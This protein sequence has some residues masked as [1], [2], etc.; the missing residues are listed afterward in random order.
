MKEKPIYIY[1]HAALINNWADVLYTQL[2]KVKKSGLYDACEAIFIGMVGNHDVIN[3]DHN[4]V[5]IVKEY[6]KIHICGYNGD[7]SL[8]ET[9]T[10]DKLH[11]HAKKEDA[12]F[13]YFHCKG[14]GYD[15]RNP[16]WLNI[17]LWRDFLEYFTIEKWEDC[18]KGLE[19]YDVAGAGWLKESKIYNGHFS[20]NFWWSKSSFLKTLPSVEKTKVDKNQFFKDGDLKY[21]GEFWLGSKKPKV[22]DFHPISSCNN[23]VSFF[24]KNL[25]FD[26]NYIN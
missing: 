6:D 3:F 11:K 17:K 2:S 9:F 10:L 7:L 14:V 23:T 15:Y 4:I 25:Y 5:P 24:Y 20:G 18:V 26:K 8:Y 1:I 13:L 16:Q 22:K 21:K 12:Y 19:E